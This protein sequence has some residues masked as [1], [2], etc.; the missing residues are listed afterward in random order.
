[1]RR[2]DLWGW[3]ASC[4]PVRYWRWWWVKP[5]LLPILGSWSKC[6]P[7]W[8]HQAIYSSPNS[9]CRVFWRKVPHLSWNLGSVFSKPFQSSLREADSG[10]CSVVYLGNPTVKAHS[11]ISFTVMWDLG[12]ILCCGDQE[13]C[14]TLDSDAK[15]GSEGKK[16]HPQQECLFLWEWFTCFSETEGLKCNWFASKWLVGLLEKRS[17]SGAQ[18]WS[19]LAAG[20]MFR[21]SNSSNALFEWES[22]LL[23]P[24]IASLPLRA[25]CL[26]AYILCLGWQMKTVNKHQSTGRIIL[27]RSWDRG[28]NYD[29]LLRYH[30]QPSSHPFVC[31][32]SYR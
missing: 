8:S 16:A 15:W 14:D 21:S 7:C 6:A 3:D 1:M 9:M 24:L 23:G 2:W 25:L 18:C 31:S 5:F 26:Y 28:S 19:V 27:A 29:F 30:R 13:L 10:W 32:S 11:H 12:Q 4:S 17:I 20:W 22:I